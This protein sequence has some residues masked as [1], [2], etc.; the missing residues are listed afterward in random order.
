MN[1]YTFDF[2]PIECRG[3]ASARR[4]EK[5]GALGKPRALCLAQSDGTYTCTRFE[6]DLYPNRIV[7]HGCFA[8]LLTGVDGWGPTEFACPLLESGW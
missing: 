7:L 5:R 3:S 2:A 1:T 4:C 8:P 6:A